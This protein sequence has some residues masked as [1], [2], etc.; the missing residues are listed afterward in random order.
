MPR[1]IGPVKYLLQNFVKIVN[2][3]KFH[4]RCLTHSVAA[5]GSNYRGRGIFRRL[6]HDNL[7][8]KQQR[9]SPKKVVL[10]NFAK[11]TRKYLCLSFFF[12]KVAGLIL[13]PVNFGI[14]FKSSFFTEHFQVTASVN[15]NIFAQ[16]LSGIFLQYQI[17]HGTDKQFYQ[18]E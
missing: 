6:C 15:R 13:R 8:Q 17:G 12:N 1:R 4:H 7:I 10:N 14:L 18:Y 3:F 11:F 2:T 5:S 9:Y 16:F